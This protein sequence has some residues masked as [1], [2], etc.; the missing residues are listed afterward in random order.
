MEMLQL[1]Y[2]Y[3]S[4]QTESFARTAEKYMVPTTSVSAAVKRLET[5]LGCALFDRTANRI[6]LN[7]NG[8]R[9]RQSLL[10]SLFYNL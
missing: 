7:E 9:F 4:A 8:R 6:M 5:E 10:I 1:R 2:F 3:E